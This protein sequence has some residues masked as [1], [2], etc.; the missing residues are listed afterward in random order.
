MATTKPEEKRV[1]LHVPRGAA[2]DEPHI[3]IGVNGVNYKLPRGKT[4]KVPA[5]VKAE[6]DRSV[7]AQEK[8]DA[9]V[10]DLLEKANT[11]LPTQ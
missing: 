3:V 4:S 9:T 1:D 2:N 8:Y 5:F 6:Y 11:S 7:A 10:D